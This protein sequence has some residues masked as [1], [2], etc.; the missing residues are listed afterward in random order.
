MNT[1]DNIFLNLK[2]IMANLLKTDLQEINQLAT[3]NSKLRDDLG[4]DS[5]ESLDFLA[6]IEKTYSIQISDKEAT[7]LER[8]SDAIDLILG[9]IKECGQ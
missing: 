8:V 2:L 1:A 6:S 5:V 9:K 3:L 4:I 7:K